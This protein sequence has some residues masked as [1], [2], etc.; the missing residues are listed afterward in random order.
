M[1]N[2][3]FMAVLALLAGLMGSPALGVEYGTDFLEPGNPGGVSGSLKTFDDE[4]TLGIGETF[5][6]D[7]WASDI[8]ETI[9]SSGFEMFY[10]P[11]Q[12]RVVKVEA[13]DNDLDGSQGKPMP[14]CQGLAGPW[15]PDTTNQL[16]D[17]YGPGSYVLI[18]A[19]LA[20]V[21]PDAGGD[22]IIARVTFQCLADG[23]SEITFQGIDN[24]DTTVGCNSAVV[25]DSQM[26]SHSI[27]ISQEGTGT[28]TTTTSSPSTTTSSIFSSTTSSPST[29][30]T[31]IKRCLSESIYGG[32]GEETRLLRHFRDTVL[33]KTAE[34]REL[35][36]LYYLWSPV[37]VSA[38]EGNEEFKTWV[39]QMIDDM[40]PMIQ[41]TV[42]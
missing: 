29:T 36:N 15:D 31:S 33:S 17:P 30:T 40:L 4:W 20:C 12:V 21:A 42:E 32:N 24:F 34:G 38:I 27:V 6:I 39:K 28:S 1:K 5:E 22:I 7:I 3:T 37:V 2:F 13:Y 14:C 16:V 26:G 41:Q 10:N 18:L 23:N 9:I 35:I 11:A 19:Q 8:P 25:Y